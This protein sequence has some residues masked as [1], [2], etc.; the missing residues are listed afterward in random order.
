MYGYRGC[1]HDV[2]LLSPYEMLLFWSMEKVFSPEACQS[3]ETRSKWTI[4]GKS[5]YKQCREQKIQPEYEAGV[6]YIAEP[7]SHR[8]LLPDVFALHGLRH[9][10]CWEKRKRPHLPK[11]SYSKV[12]SAKQS[13]EENARMLCVYMRPWTLD[14]NTQT[15]DNPL[16]HRLGVC[17]YR[18]G[19]QTPAWLS[20]KEPMQRPSHLA[21]RLHSKTY[22][23]LPTNR[24]MAC[25]SKDT[26]GSSPP[27]AAA[28]KFVSYACSW[29]SYISGHVISESSRRFICN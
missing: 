21:K 9:K 20:D 5:Y 13:P 2:D 11:W 22:D 14:K 25:S 12:P 23:A 3:G 24:N 15:K 26:T 18:D 27:I 1:E 8:I 19:I 28:E 4:E 6:H 7:A 16:L 17:S 10:W 29:E